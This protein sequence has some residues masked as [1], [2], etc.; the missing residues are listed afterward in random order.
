[1][2]F[3]RRQNWDIVGRSWLWLGLSAAFILFGMVWWAAHGM[4][5]GID[6]TGGVL[7]RYEMESPILGG[8]TEE[9]QILR[10]LRQELQ[11]HGLGSSQLQISGND[12]LYIRVAEVE[13]GQSG[14]A[15]MEAEILS[16]FQKVLGD[17]YG[18]ITVGDRERVGPIVGEQ[19]RQSAIWALILGMA[20]ILIYIA[21]RYEFRFAVAA[22]A[23]LLH[24][25]LIM[26][27]FVA[28]LQ[29]ELDSSFVAAI[30]TVVGYSINDTVVIFDRIRENRKL[31][32]GADFNATVNSSLL[33]TMNRSLNTTFTTLITLTALFVWG[34]AT[35]RNFV[36]VLIIGIAS[37]VYSSLFTSSPIISLWYA[38]SQRQAQRAR[39]ARASRGAASASAAGSRAGNSQGMGR[40]AARD[41]DNE[42]TNVEPEAATA[43]SGVDATMRTAEAKV[44]E[45]KREERRRRR[46]K[47][48]AGTKKRY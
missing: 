38:H 16:S 9:R 23:G 28:L 7:L 47:K 32:R 21:I 42:T 41:A 26:V 36:L 5:Y 10:G 35:I 24:D 17:K 37:G 8:H 18:E 27:A 14:A 3:F 43:P 6:F 13:G 45:E 22:V 46:K 2:D 4:N 33:Q 31:H 1:V 11:Q 29:I 25:I 20:L 12:Q 39:A 34:G 30:L 40:K 48:P 15:S 19:L 44:R